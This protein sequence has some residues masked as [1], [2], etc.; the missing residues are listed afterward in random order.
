[1]LSTF[2][3][4]KCGHGQQL[5]AEGFIDFESKFWEG[6]KR[7]DIS[8]FIEKGKNDFPQIKEEKGNA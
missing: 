1:M 5:H 2:I 6:V 7:H 8:L 3:E 4:K